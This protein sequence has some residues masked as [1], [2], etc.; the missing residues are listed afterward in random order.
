M[1]RERAEVGKL[2]SRE[3]PPG[4]H[5]TTLAYSDDVMLC[6]FRMLKGAKIP[7][8]SHPQVQ[9]GYVVSG[10]VSF[11]RADGS[12]FEAGPGTSYVFDSRE[13]HGAEVLEDAEVIEVF[14]PVRP[15]YADN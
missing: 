2:R 4:I 15:E 7:L 13:E 8:H 14:A 10:R 11:K 1:K 5:R 3:N 12:S 9:T 6:H